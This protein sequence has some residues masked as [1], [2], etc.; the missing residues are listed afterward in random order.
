MGDKMFRQLH[1]LRTQASVIVHALGCSGRAFARFK[2]RHLPL[3]RC[4]SLRIDSVVA[5]LG[6]DSRPGEPGLGRMAGM[7]CSLPDGT[8]R[9]KV[10]LSLNYPRP[11][12][13]PSGLDGGGNSNRGRRRRQQHQGGPRSLLAGRGKNC[14]RGAAIR[15]HRADVAMR[16]RCAACF[17]A[18]V[19]M[20][21]DRME[22]ICL[23]N[24]I[25]QRGAR[26][27]RRTSQGE[28][29]GW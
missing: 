1:H 3:H 6:Q 13:G 26:R 16:K 5:W 17:P 11:R 27:S 22:R 25:S 29:M 23:S 9:A 18:R 24:S 12:P 28:R 15:G 7:G 4:T 10:P 8:Y 20:R 19:R 21:E 14:S 2:C